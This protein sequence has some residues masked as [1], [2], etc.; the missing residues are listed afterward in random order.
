MYY[1]AFIFNIFVFCIITDLIFEDILP[2][3]LK[4]DRNKK[5]VI[6]RSQLQTCFPLFFTVLMGPNFLKGV[7]S[8][9][10][11]LQCPNLNKQVLKKYFL[12]QI[13]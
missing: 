7:D 3:T 2:S 11:F 13:Q 4:L 6:A 10:E 5:M 8:L 12:N 1:E 9:F